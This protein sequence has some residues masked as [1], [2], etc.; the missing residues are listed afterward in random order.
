MRQA[1]DNHYDEFTDVI[2]PF[3]PDVQDA[4]DRVVEE[5]ISVGVTFKVSIWRKLGG[6]KKRNWDLMA[7]NSK[8]ISDETTEFVDDKGTARECVE[9]DRYKLVITGI[10][11]VIL[12][13]D[14]ALSCNG[15]QIKSFVQLKKAEEQR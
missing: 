3:V 13:V 5:R 15:H 4:V 7:V 9:V 12:N 10:Q 11:G 8:K 14:V 6:E 2:H 1:V